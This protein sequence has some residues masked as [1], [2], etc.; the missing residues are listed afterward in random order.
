M[1]ENGHSDLPPLIQRLDA[2]CAAIGRC[3]QFEDSAT[4]IQAERDARTASLYW[5]RR[6]LAGSA[7]S[8]TERY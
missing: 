5:E 3:R 1:I 2:T 6:R 4:T 8:T 7:G